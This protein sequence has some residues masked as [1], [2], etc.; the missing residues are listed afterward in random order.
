MKPS[1]QLK[2]LTTLVLAAAFLALG[3]IT[4]ALAVRDLRRGVEWPRAAHYRSRLAD[5]FF[6]AVRLRSR[7]L[8]DAFRGEARFAHAPDPRPTGDLVGHRPITP[9]RAVR[10]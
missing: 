7:R 6:S 1:R 8:G 5:R 2:F 4:T 3:W 10:E 9:Y